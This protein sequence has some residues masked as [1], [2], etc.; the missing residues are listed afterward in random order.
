MTIETKINTGVG[1]D[2]WNELMGFY[3]NEA[4]TLDERKYDEWL[5]LFSD[6]LF[7]FMPRRKNVLRRET[8]RELTKPGDMSFFEETKEMMQVRITRLETGMA[9]SEDP[10]SRTR[11]LVGNLQVTSATEDEIK[12][13]T[14]FMV[15]KSHLETDTAFYTGYREDILRRT[16]AGLKVASRT[17]VL[18][19]NVL[20]SKNIS[21]FF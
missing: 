14:A 5:A 15:F 6:D 3:I 2:L 17:I 8:A 4:W 10:P 9:W 21:I 12:A 11:H 19:A 13:R 1:S 16:D 20:L 18:D 7:Y